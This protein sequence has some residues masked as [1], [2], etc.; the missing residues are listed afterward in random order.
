MPEEDVTPNVTPPTPAGE[1]ADLLER[2]RGALLALHGQGRQANGQA[3][4]GNFFG[5]KTGLR[6]AQ[7]LDQPDIAAW[8]REEVAAILTDLGG[9]E[10]L[11]ALAR[12][13]VCEVARLKVILS[14]LGTELL[15]G[16][17]LTPKGRGRAAMTVYLQVLDRYQRLAAS[18]GLERRQK[19]VHPLEAV[20]QAVAEANNK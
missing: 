9:D 6:S 8:H 18:L 13:T 10:E 16:G 11:S 1:R 5:L 2:A 12:T 14:A 4:Q 17:V 15:E 20:R 7:L 3:G 19:P